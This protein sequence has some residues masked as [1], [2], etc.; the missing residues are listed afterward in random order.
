M[1]L[2][3]IIVVLYSCIIVAGSIFTVSLSPLSLSLLL[4]FLN[5]ALYISCDSLDHILH[6]IA[7]HTS[8]LVCRFYHNMF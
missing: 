8:S 1:C 7:L 2:W 3:F 5:I 6:Q 4:Y